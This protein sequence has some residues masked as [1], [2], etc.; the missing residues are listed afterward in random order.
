MDKET[1]IIKAF[2]NL[3]QIDFILNEL[4]HLYFL[5]GGTLLGAVRE[6]DFC[7]DDYDDID[8]TIISED[9]SDCVDS[10]LHIIETAS[11]H[12]F[13]L[14]RF[15]K[16]EEKKTAQIVL[17][18]D[19]LKI[20]IMFKRIKGDKIWWTIYGGP[21]RITYKRT[22]AKFAIKSSTH[23]R[24]KEVEIRNKKFLAPYEAEKYL[25]F[26]Y[27]DWTKKIHRSEYSCYK[28]DK[29]I[30]QSYEKI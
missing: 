26:R 4:G 16:R 5:D 3:C 13:A 28:T 23:L 6:R 19:E 8:L 2:H 1:Q 15:W 27:G 11:R 20:D 30:V 21:N 22:P 24:L 25:T 18:K 14:K 9:G 12:G 29:S 7:E 10:I 17:T